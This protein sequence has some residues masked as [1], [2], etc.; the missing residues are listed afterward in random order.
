MS[1]RFFRTGSAWILMLLLSGCN[2]PFS[3]VEQH[4]KYQIPEGLAD[5]LYTQ[6][7]AQDNLT[8]YTSALEITGYD[9]IF[10]VSGSYTL[11]APSNSAFEQFFQDYPNYQSA[12]T[13]HKARR[14]VAVVFN[15]F[16]MSF[17][18]SL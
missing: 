4:E 9:K 11:L 13:R 1:S 10:D 18:F 14:H 16:V 8:I 3:G 15:A 17:L 2:N 6:V 7:K 5:N 12:N